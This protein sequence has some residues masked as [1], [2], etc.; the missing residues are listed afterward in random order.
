M[1]FLFRVDGDRRMGLGHVMRCRA[2]AEA[3]IAA[4][5]NCV[6][7]CAGLEPSLAAAL[8][9]TGIAVEAIDIESDHEAAV[10]LDLATKL[11]A[12]GL[13]V[14]GYHFS[15]PWR[16]ALRRAGVPVLAFADGP[17]RPDHADLL[18]DAASPT[19]PD[20]NHLFGPDYVLLRRELVEAARLPPLPMEQRQTILVTFGGSD[21][22][23]LT[24]PTV[25]ALHRLLPE[26]TLRVVIGGAAADGQRVAAAALALGPKIEVRIAPS[27][28][29]HLMREAGLAVS[30]AGGTVGELAALAVPLVLAVVADNQVTG[31]AACEAAGWCKPIDARGGTDAAE[32]LAVAAAE[33]WRDPTERARRATLARSTID[34]DGARRVAIA[35]LR[36]IAQHAGAALAR[37]IETAKEKLTE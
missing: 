27:R 3:L 30:A 23:G 20:P 14:D 9:D 35:F 37:L 7:V 6:F 33:L 16:A 2:L 19:S 32:L 10:T 5:D 15:A 17:F 25:T 24:L 18:I 1:N 28:M 29:G 34:P 36:V 8:R 26:V 22:A 21:P 4:G 11:R 13:I 31:A 12:N